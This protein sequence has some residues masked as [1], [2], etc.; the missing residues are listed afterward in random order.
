MIHY[1]IHQTKTRG[2]T[3]AQS[4]RR[5]DAFSRVGWI[6]AP[7]PSGGTRCV[8]LSN[9]LAKA[10]LS[11][12]V[13]AQMRRGI[14]HP[15]VAGT[16]FSSPTYV[17]RSRSTDV[18]TFR[19]SRGTCTFLTLPYLSCGRR[20]LSTLGL[21]I[22][23]GATATTCYSTFTMLCVSVLWKKAAASLGMCSTDTRMS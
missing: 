7:Q 16:S 21:V 5:A 18:P 6:A 10:S 2:P 4:H 3:K 13:A 14:H 20:K 22:L 23:C 17:A 1:L 12:I 15:R 8:S 11:T 9:G 19:P